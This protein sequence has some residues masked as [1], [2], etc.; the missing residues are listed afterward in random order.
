MKTLTRLLMSAGLVLVFCSTQA[1]TILPGGYISGNLT[2]LASPYHVMGDLTVQCGQSLYMQGGVTLIFEGDYSLDVYGSIKAMGSDES[3][4]LFTKA[5]GIDHW[6]GVHI[7]GDHRCPDNLHSRLQYIT[8]EYASAGN[9]PDMWD[10]SGGALYIAW[11]D[12]VTIRNCVFRNNYAVGG[13]PDLSIGGGAI[14]IDRCNPV[15]E[16]CHFYDNVC[17]KYGGAIG[18]R[19]ASPLMKYNI[20]IDNSAGMNAVGGG[21]ALF[22]QGES[23]PRLQN[24]SYLNNTTNGK[25]GAVY[26][27]D[28]SDPLFVNSLLWGNRADEGSQVYIGD[29]GS[30]PCFSYCDVEG[31]KNGFEGP[32]TGLNFNG[33]FEHSFDKMPLCVHASGSGYPYMLTRCSPCIDAGNPACC[34][35]DPDGTRADI[36]AMYYPHSGVYLQEPLVE[37]VWSIYESPLYVNTDLTVPEN[38]SLDIDAGCEIVFLGTYGLEVKGSLKAVGNNDARIRFKADPLS[39]EWRGIKFRPGS[40]TSRQSEISFCTIEDAVADGVDEFDRMGGGVLIHGNDNVL[41]SFNVI[42]NNRS[43][44]MQ[45]QYT[46]GGGVAIIDCSPT[47]I[48]NEISGNR[49]AEFGGGIGLYNASPVLHHNLVVNNSAGIGGG[50]IALFA[51]SDP[52]MTNLTIAHNKAYQAGGGMMLSQDADPKVT[53][54]ILWYNTAG[55]GNQVYLNDENSDPDFYYN[56]M[57]GGWKD[58]KGYGTMSFEG[59]Y[60]NNIED[61][62]GFKSPGYGL[63]GYSPC[64]DAGHPNSRQDPDGTRA[65]I[66]AYYYHS[67][68]IHGT[69]GIDDP[70]ANDARV[71]FEVFPLPAIDLIYIDS[72][73]SGNRGAEFQ[74]FNTLGQLVQKFGR[75]PG[76]NEKSRMQL[77]ISDY[78]AGTY[79]LRMVSGNEVYTGKFIKK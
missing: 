19:D 38:A 24:E 78:D 26:L 65:D 46:G 1:Q 48:H 57:E 50:G 20:F 10:Q 29:P 76:G 39:G 60:L 70:P 63:W 34:Y 62:P 42:R 53:N 49:A 9:G 35:K 5:E 59:D 68:A 74:V 54:S 12:R 67:M 8:F 21:A 22:I 61:A 33:T 58:V 37:G 72:Y 51:N 17:E 75:T 4:I 36:G 52:V 32:G 27:L 71:R 40:A 41:L 44:E 43:T 6:G 73:T 64:I 77:D 79:I 14:A 3:P 56:D 66:G 11:D 30:D 18:L 45:G 69:L 13:L 2:K 7:F 25:G 15:I 47:L 55:Y 28:D 16:N 31:G 23:N